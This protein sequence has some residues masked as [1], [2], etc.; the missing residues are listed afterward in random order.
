MKKGKKYILLCNNNFLNLFYFIFLYGNKLWVE[1]MF[2]IKIDD[3]IKLFL[4][5]VELIVWLYLIVKSFGLWCDKLY[6]DFYFF[7]SK[8]WFLYKIR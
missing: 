2:I 4:L 7:V 8:L 6:Y 5:Y 1:M 3:F